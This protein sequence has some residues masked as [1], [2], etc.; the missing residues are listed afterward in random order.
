MLIAKSTFVRN[1][2]HTVMQK[3][4]AF[5][6]RSLI[7]KFA[8]ISKVPTHLILTLKRFAYDPVKQTR[9]KIMTEVNYPLSI[10]IPE[11]TVTSE[12]SP[13]T[14]GKIYYLIHFQE[15]E[16]SL[17]A[18][19]MHSGQSIDHGHYYCYARHSELATKGSHNPRYVSNECLDDSSQWYLF[20]DSNVALSSFESFS[21]ITK[22]FRNDVAYILFYRLKQDSEATPVEKGN[23]NIHKQFILQ[24]LNLFQFSYQMK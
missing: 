2:M 10:K 22:T 7:L 19:V 11:E 6:P 23:W 17:Y 13:I 21:K 5:Y 8:H 20:N 3:R 24:F 1:A 15:R 18:V 16:Y 9:N 12:N 4:Y 14:K